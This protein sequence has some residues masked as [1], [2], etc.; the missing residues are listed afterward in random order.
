MYLWVDNID[1]WLDSPGVWSSR[2]KFSGW[3]R[4]ARLFIVNDILWAVMFP[5]IALED[6]VVVDT[7]VRFFDFG[8]FFGMFLVRGLALG[9]LA[10]LFFGSTVVFEVV[11]VGSELVVVITVVEAAVVIVLP[12]VVP[13]LEV[14][15]RDKGG[16]V[17]IGWR[18]VQNVVVVSPT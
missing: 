14:V 18:M 16:S 5:A 2:F 7:F 3:S 1:R 17:T 15:V 12:E 6:L 10:V 9:R 8:L 11:D 13:R 4:S